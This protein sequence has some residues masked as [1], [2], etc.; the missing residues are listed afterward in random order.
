MEL[1][2]GLVILVMTCV[3]YIVEEFV[4][5]RGQKIVIKP[6]TLLKFINFLLIFIF[7]L[8]VIYIISLKNFPVVEFISILLLNPI[9]VMLIMYVVYLRKNKILINTRNLSYKIDSYDDLQTLNREINITYN[10]SIAEYLLN[11]SID[12]KALVAD[13]MNLYAKKIIQIQE[14]IINDKKRYKFNINSETIK[15]TKIFKSDVYII[16]SIVLKKSKFDFSHWNK[17]VEDTFLKLGVHKTNSKVYRVKDLPKPLLIIF[18]SS[19][20]FARLL[21]KESLAFQITMSLSVMS[22]SI[23]PILIMFD[24][25]NSKVV[26]KINLNDIGREEAKNWIKFEKFVKEY[27]LLKDKN[28]EDI[29]IYERYIPFAIALGINLNYEDTIYSIFNK[30]ELKEILADIADKEIFGVLFL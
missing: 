29:I 27:T 14:Q 5:S 20:L 6:K 21:S 1:V 4:H 15:S 9:S 2:L 19:L 8:A 24:Y 13:I 17:L 26:Q 12:E 16:D 25:F 22:A 11:G 30:S 3:I 7:L 18:A 10:P 23:I 28:I